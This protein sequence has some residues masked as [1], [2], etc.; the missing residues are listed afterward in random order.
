MRVRV[1]RSFPYAADHIHVEMLEAGAEVD[2]ADD[3]APGLLAEG[4]VELPKADAPST[5]D[6]PE[7]ARRRR[8]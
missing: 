6:A 3:C 8:G 4:F 5:S 2:V 7:P 1:I